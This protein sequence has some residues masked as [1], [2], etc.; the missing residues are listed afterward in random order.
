MNDIKLGGVSNTPFKTVN[1]LAPAFPYF[2]LPDGMSTIAERHLKLDIEQASA[3]R[4]ICINSSLVDY[5]LKSFI[6]NTESVMMENYKAPLEPNYGYMR[7][8]TSFQS[9]SVLVNNT[10]GTTRAEMKKCML[11]Q[12]PTWLTKD[13]SHGKALS[14]QFLAEYSAA[15]HA[16]YMY[17]I[18]LGRV[19]NYGERKELSN[20]RQ[21]I[22]VMTRRRADE[23][24]IVMPVHIWNN[25]SNEL[26]R[27][28]TTCHN[29]LKHKALYFTDESEWKEHLKVCFAG[30][31]TPNIRSN[32]RS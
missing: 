30:E 14:L 13:R 29:Y 5:R 2:D 11:G 15:V 3:A 21:E 24:N 22:G 20:P 18:K 26:N 7:E 32:S 25:Q 19:S 4:A 10:T 8:N 9:L 27:E 23:P 1:I 17:A 12:T 28:G 16:D 31:Q 6:S